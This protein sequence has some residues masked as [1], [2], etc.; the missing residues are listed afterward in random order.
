MLQ[1]AYN[2]SV[3]HDAAGENDLQNYNTHKAAL[4]SCLSGLTSGSDSA[5][6]FNSQLAE[7]TPVV[8][9]AC[10]TFEQYASATQERTELFS[11]FVDEQASVSDRLDNFKTGLLKHL[12]LSIVVKESRHRYQKEQ[13]DRLLVAENAY[14]L[15]NQG[16][17]LDRFCEEYAKIIEYQV[18][19]SNNFKCP[20]IRANYDDYEENVIRP[21][22]STIF[23]YF[24]SA[25]RSRK[26]AA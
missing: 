4:S 25:D 14:T 23:Y 18:E 26:A 6:L 7:T 24:F 15:K 12:S 8:E 3:E 11:N 19:S 1:T 13:F 10:S 2:Q 9:G 22:N 21:L 20:K 16:Q 17:S 5:N